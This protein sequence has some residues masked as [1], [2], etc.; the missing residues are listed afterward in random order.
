VRIGTGA[1]NLRIGKM[2]CNDKVIVRRELPK[3]RALLASF[4]PTRCDCDAAHPGIVDQSAACASAQ[5]I[6][7]L[8]SVPVIGDVKL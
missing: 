7:P 6:E 8:R 4:R 3:I 2:R 1:T 5:D